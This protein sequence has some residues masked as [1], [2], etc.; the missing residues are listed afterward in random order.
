MIK[1]LDWNVP[2]NQ[3]KINSIVFEMA[4]H[5]IFAL[6]ILHLQSGVIT[7]FFR[8]GLGDFFMAVEAFEDRGFRAEHVTAVA[9]TCATKAFMSF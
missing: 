5:A 2:V 3:V 6:R 1:L 9:L 7:V 4:V 8:K